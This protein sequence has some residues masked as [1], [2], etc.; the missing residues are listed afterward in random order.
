MTEQAQ[1]H[2]HTPGPLDVEVRDTVYAIVDQRGRDV[3]YVEI[4]PCWG[5]DDEPCGSLT[6]RGRTAG[7]LYASAHLFAAAPHMLAALTICAD[8]LAELGDR[9]FTDAARAA[10]AKATGGRG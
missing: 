2:K 7:E 4:A 5:P 3:I 9:Y 6:S 10:I 1:Q 8:R